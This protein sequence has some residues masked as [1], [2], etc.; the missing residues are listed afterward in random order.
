MLIIS[1]TAKISRL[2]DIEDSQRGSK[3]IIEDGVTIDSF[4]KIKPAGGSGDLVIGA[5]SVI[6]PG[7]VMYT[8]NG[9]VIGKHVMIAANCV[10]SAASHEFMDKTMNVMN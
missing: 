4:V 6:N 9:L 10:L 2:A 7:V 5:H 8:G 1:T 3:I